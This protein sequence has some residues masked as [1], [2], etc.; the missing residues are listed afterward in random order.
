MPNQDP[1]EVAIIGAGP[2]GLELAVTLKRAGIRYVQF[3]A[4]QIG[5]T[6]MW[7][8]PGTRWFSSNE[9]IAIAGV[10]LVT[11]DQG[12]AT[13]ELYLAYLRQIVTMFDLDVRTYEPLT[14]VTRTDDG[15]FEL[16]TTSRHGELL[17]RS[18][19][20]VLCVGGTDR[21]RRLGIPGEDLPHVSAYFNE[22]HAF[23][24][25]KVLIIGGRNSAVKQRCGVIT[26]GR[27]S[28]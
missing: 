4:G 12:K 22:P 18:K 19:R 25:Q 5:A 3:E 14:G 21:P 28:R 1:Y 9:R 7:W 10:P 17:T 11:P 20:I 6:M 23:F 8:S 24:Q 15:S 13:R 16:K 2:I 26:P 27:K